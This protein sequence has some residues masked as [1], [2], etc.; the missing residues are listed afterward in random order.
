[1]Y[2]KISKKKS[3]G[4]W[5]KIKEKDVGVRRMGKNILLRPSSNGRKQNK[6][7]GVLSFMVV[8]F[9]L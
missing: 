8:D 9:Y 3:V 1:M 5:T 4:E 2:M 7:A 6:L